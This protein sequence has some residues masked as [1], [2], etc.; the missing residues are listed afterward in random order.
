MLCSVTP[1]EGEAPGVAPQLG[2][3]AH[4]RI[5]NARLKCAK[6]GREQRVRLWGAKGWDRQGWPGRCRRVLLGHAS[7]TCEKAELAGRGLR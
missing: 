7:N 3:V 4:C 2:R 1:G 5:G 6:R